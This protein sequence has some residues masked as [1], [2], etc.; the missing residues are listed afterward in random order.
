MDK[1]RKANIEQFLQDPGEPCH[2]GCS[3]EEYADMAD[4]ARE[5]SPLKRCS[6][7]DWGWVDL[8]VG[9]EKLGYIEGRNTRPGVLYADYCIEDE[10]RRFYIGSWVRTT[11]LA[12]FV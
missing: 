4:R 9:E 3:E 1:S 11:P 10:L 7:K 5:I 12:K 2:L 8:D 6:V